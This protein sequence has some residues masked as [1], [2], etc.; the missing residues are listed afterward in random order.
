MRSTITLPGTISTSASPV[1]CLP[2]FSFLLPA[3][4]HKKESRRVDSNR[5]PAHYEFAVKGSAQYREVRKMP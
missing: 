1:F 5:F 3:N 4:T 2:A